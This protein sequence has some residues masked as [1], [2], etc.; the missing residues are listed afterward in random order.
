MFSC[1]KGG[2]GCHGS[3]H[4]YASCSGYMGC[5]GCTGGVMM[6]PAPMGAP[7]AA[8]AP[9]PTPKGAEPRPATPRQPAS[10]DA[11]PAKVLVSLPADAKLSIDGNSTVSTSSSRTFVSP[12][13]QVGKDYVYTMIA[14][15]SVDGKIVSESKTITVRAGETT[16]VAFDLAPTVAAK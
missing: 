11:A 3:C 14:E 12:D 13:L 2:H 16:Q 8:P 15:L 1:F 7:S 5:T 10:L 9:A 4:G 6:N